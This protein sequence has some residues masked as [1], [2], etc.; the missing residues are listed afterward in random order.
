M[1]IRFKNVEKLRQSPLNKKRN[2][3]TRVSKCE[4]KVNGR[5]K[6]LSRLEEL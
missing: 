3:I 2:K 1:I 4:T 6:L 5:F